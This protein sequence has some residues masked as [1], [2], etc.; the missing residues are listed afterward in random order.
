MMKRSIGFAA[1]LVVAG[2]TLGNFAQIA[3]AEPVTPGASPVVT[4]VTPQPR[5]TPHP[6]W[7]RPLRTSSYY[8]YS[9]VRPFQVAS[10]ARNDCFW[11]N[12]RVTGLGF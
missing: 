7:R 8:S 5:I 12:V 6:H 9:P 11:C 10:I 1:A 4:R 3:R 2:M